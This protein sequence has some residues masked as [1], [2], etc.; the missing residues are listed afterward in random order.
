MEIRWFENDQLIIAPEDTK[1]FR[2]S[3]G[4]GGVFF[5]PPSIIKEKKNMK[6]P[7][8]DELEVF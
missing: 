3:I 4:I 8:A 1:G 6:K 7:R 5:T 2:R